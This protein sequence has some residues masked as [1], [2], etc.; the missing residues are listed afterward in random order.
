MKITD[1]ELLSKIFLTTAQR[2]PYMATYKYIGGK[3]S[4]G[5]NDEWSQ[6]YATWICTVF[7][8]KA[9]NTGLSN[10]QSMNRIIRLIALG[11]LASEKRVPGQAFHFKLPDEITKPMFA[12]TFELLIENGITKEPADVSGFDGIAKSI[13]ETLIAEFGDNKRAA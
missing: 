3:R 12:R 9:L 11:E 13:T 2:L 5:S 4:L 7:R 10:T 8:E 1:Q 6:K